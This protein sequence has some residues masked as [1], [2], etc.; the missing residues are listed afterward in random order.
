MISNL[1]I[2]L[3]GGTG[4]WSRPYREAGYCVEL[5]DILNGRDVRLLQRLNARAQGVLCAP[6]CTVFSYA[7]NRYE[8]TE[9]EY[10]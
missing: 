4:E 6:V 7:R 9:A 1:I 3:C 2:D 8:P 10:P 5:V